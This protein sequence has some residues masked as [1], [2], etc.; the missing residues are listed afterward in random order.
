MIEFL[1][2]ASM[3]CQDATKM[4]GRI[5]KITYMSSDQVEEVIEVIRN[6]TPECSWD[7]NDWRNGA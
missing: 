4:I 6:S 2:Y 3:S 7:E 5:Q 1:L